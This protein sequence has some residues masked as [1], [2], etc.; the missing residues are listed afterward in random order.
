MF[1]DTY[2]G[3]RN[4]L[5]LQQGCRY[6]RKAICLAPTI[7]ECFKENG[8]LICNW[9]FDEEGLHWATQQDESTVVYDS[10]NATITNQS[11][12]AYLVQEIKLKLGCYNLELEVT[13]TDSTA[14]IIL[15]DEASNVT[16]LL[17][18]LTVGVHP[19]ELTI[20]TDG[21]YQLGFGVNGPA[22]STATF[23]Y[24][25]TKEIE[26]PEGEYLMNSQFD[27][28]TF[29]WTRNPQY[30]ATITDNGD[31]SIHLYADTNFGSVVPAKI[32][33][34]DANWIIEVSVKNQTGTKGGKISIQRP[35]NRWDTVEFGSVADG[36]YRNEYSGVIKTIDVGA[37]SE[38]GFEMD[39]EYYSLR[40]ADSDIV[41]YYGDTVTYDGRP[42]LYGSDYKKKG[43]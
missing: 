30:N 35:N 43:E 27:C 32:P 9:T 8:E 24:M 42:V 10:G 5:N 34:E 3:Y 37:N 23:S 21:T 18:G 36:I 29:M 1:R 2:F 25:S 20:D 6:T 40:K 7:L 12:D 4:S 39:F 28:G 41:T 31:G 19:F 33:T 11:D 16:K 17:D 15:I 14:Y 26:Q 38:A 13:A 22:G